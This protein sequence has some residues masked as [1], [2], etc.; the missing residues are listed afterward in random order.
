MERILGVCIYHTLFEKYLGTDPSLIKSFSLR[1]RKKR[2]VEAL[3]RCIL[4]SPSHNLVTEFL[5]S[6]LMGLYNKAVPFLCHSLL[7]LG[8]SDMQCNN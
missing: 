2:T 5:H 8:F 7:K 1:R 6:T 3:K 4:A